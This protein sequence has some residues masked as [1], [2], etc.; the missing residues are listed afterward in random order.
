MDKRSYNWT[1]TCYS[2]EM[3]KFDDTYMTYLA[4]QPETCPESGRKH[5]QGFICLKNAKTLSALLKLIG[6]HHLEVMKGTIDQNERYCSKARSKNGDFVEFGIK[7]T[8]GKRS[9]LIEVKKTALTKGMRGCVDETYNYQ[10]LRTAE[11]YLK[12][13][14]PCRNWKPF[15]LWIWGPSG[16]GNLR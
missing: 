9:D 7:P 5:Y 2:A 6:P 4:Y 8:Q 10:Q 16:S 12:H 1:I 3:I 14:E 15:V 13:R 11:I